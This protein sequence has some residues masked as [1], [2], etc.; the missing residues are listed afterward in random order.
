MRL[1]ILVHA[2]TPLLQAVNE[3]TTCQ[4]ADY[5]AQVQI[6]S[7]EKYRREL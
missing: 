3:A 1:Q 4:Q 6:M 5:P 7:N 2:R